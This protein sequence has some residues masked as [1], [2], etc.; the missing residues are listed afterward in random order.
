MRA[1]KGKTMANEAKSVELEWTDPESA[2]ERTDREAA[3][4]ER[5]AVVRWLRK[6]GARLAQQDPR[7]RFDHFDIARLIEHGVHL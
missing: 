6:E 5:A 3:S 4:R 2:D 7:E 1:K